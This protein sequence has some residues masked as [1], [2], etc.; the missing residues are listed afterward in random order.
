MDKAKMPAFDL[1]Q[2]LLKPLLVFLLIEIIWNPI[3]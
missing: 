1:L 3:S 2:R